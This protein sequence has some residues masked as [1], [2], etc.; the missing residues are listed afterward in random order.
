MS[1]K[2][3]QISSQSLTGTVSLKQLIVLRLFSEMGC[4]CPKL[5]KRLFPKRIHLFFAG[6]FA[7]VTIEERRITEAAAVKRTASLSSFMAWVTYGSNAGSPRWAIA[8]SAAIRTSQLLSDV[9]PARAFALRGSR[10]AASAVAA[11]ARTGDA[12]SLL[13]V[14]IRNKFSIKLPAG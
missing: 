14:L 8:S 9:A 6:R 4:D 11:A 2:R 13:N 1:A 3:D 10:S 7:L 12:S 5:A